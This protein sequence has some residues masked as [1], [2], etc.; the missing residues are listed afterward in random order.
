MQLDPREDRDL[1]ATLRRC[2]AGDPACL[3]ELEAACGRQAAAMLERA[4][5]DPAV[6]SFILPAILID[7]R[8]R[9]S[10]FDPGLHAPD[11]WIYGVVRGRIRELTRAAELLAT[12]RPAVRLPPGAHAAP[13]PRRLPWLLPVGGLAVVAAGAAVAMIMTGSEPPRVA[14]PAPGAKPQSWVAPPVAMAPPTP[15]PVLDMPKAV[16]PPAPAPPP[17]VP[18]PVERPRH[19]VPPQATNDRV[20]A[21]P[22]AV[23]P[24]LE[25][26]AAVP[27]RVFIHYTEGSPADRAMAENIAERLA[28]QGIAVVAIRPVPF[29][30]RAA[31]VRY[32]FSGD[33]EVASRLARTHGGLIGGRVRTADFTHY[34]P[35]PAVGTVEIWLPTR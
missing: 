26:D 17:A 11:D 33:R 28:G 29:A 4:L 30:I 1:A 16:V 18:I 8:D 12:V 20:A 9:A 10:R 14:E 22:F 24:P 3:G 35:K 34:E 5:G 19:E 31:N 23:P 25:A 32:F 27:V 15:A 6:A 2:A 13:R 7:L 21:E